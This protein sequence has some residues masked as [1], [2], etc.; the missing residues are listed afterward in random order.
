MKT[1]DFEPGGLSS[2]TALTPLGFEP[3]AA[4]QQP[5]QQEE[6]Y[7]GA[8]QEFGEGVAGGIIG[9]G[10]GI[11]ELGTALVDVAAGTDY[12]RSVSEGSRKLK[13]ALGIDPAG[14]IGK[15]AEI[16]TQFVIPGLGVAGAVS[17][18]SK[19]G[20]LQK[21][22]QSGKASALPGKGLT[23]G[24][25]FSL[26]LQ[27]VAA[28]AAVDAVVANDGTTT[29]GDFFGGGP[30]MT[31][32][33]IGAGGRENALRV[34]LNKGKIGI[35]AG[36]A[37]VAAAGA[38][39][40]MGKAAEKTGKYMAQA[41]LD[42]LRGA[43]D[44]FSDAVA[45]GASV[46][47]Y[48]G[49]LPDEVAQAKSLVQ[50][51]IESYISSAKKIARRLD[52]QVE[53]LVK[54][55]ARTG[56]TP[57]QKSQVYNLIDEFLTS[58]N[59]EARQRAFDLLP[60]NLQETAKLMRGS[61][62]QLSTEILDSNYLARLDE[63]VD[64]KNPSATLG[65]EVREVIQNNI[66]TYFRRRFRMFEMDGKFVPSDEVKAR[67]VEGFKGDRS[68]TAY[69]LGKI[70][71]D[72]IAS[73]KGLY[74]EASL[75]IQK[76]DNGK[77]EMIST[78]VTD[79][80]AKL[81]S[82]GF[83][84]RYKPSKER[85][86]LTGRIA[87]NKINY[88]MFNER[89]FMPKYQRD[90]LGE[91]TDV[92]EAYLGTV[93]DL[94]EFIATDRYFG[95]IDQLVKAKN[96]DGTFTN[97][98]VRALF[99]DTRDAEGLVGKNVPD[100]MKLL[101]GDDWGGLTGYAVDNKIYNDLTRLVI[102]D[103]GV[104]GNAARGLYSTFL[105]GKGFTQY[106]KTVLSIPTQIR[107]VTSAALF[108]TMQG[109]VG[110]GA[111]IME[112]F[113]LVWRPFAEKSSDEQ[114]KE[115]QKMQ[116][117]GVF[118]NQAQLKEMKEAISQGLGF[119][120]DATIGGV[121]V[122]RGYADGLY[123][124][125]F[126]PFLKHL[127][128]LTQGAKKVGEVAE[129]FYQGGD[130]LWKYYNYK[131]ERQK[132]VN[133]LDTMSREEGI[134]WLSKGKGLPTDMTFDDLIDTYAANIVRNVVPN[135]NLAP[136]FIRGLRKLPIGNFIAFPYEIYR[137]T[138]NTLKQG[139]DEMASNNAAVRAI[140][141]RR[142][143]GALATTT[144]V[145]ASLAQI[146][147][148]LTDVT[149]EETAAYQRSIS[150]DWEKN[151]T[152][153]PIGRNEDGVPIY[154][155]FSYTNPY[156]LL[157]K[158]VVGVLNEAEKGGLQGKDTGSIV[159]NAINAG[160][161]ELYKPFTEES[162]IAGLLRDVVDPDSEQ[163][164]IPGEAI[165]GQ[166]IGGRGGQRISGAKVY[167]DEDSWDVKLQKKVNHVV[168]GMAPGLFPW[169]VRGG[170]YELG[171]FGQSIA[172]AFVEEGE[173][174]RDRYGREREIGQELVRL[175]TGISQTE[176]DVPL[177]LRYRGYEFSSRLKNAANIFTNVASRQNATK[178]DFLNAYQRSQEARFRIKNDMYLMIQDM[179][180]LGMDE[181]DIKRVFKKAGIGGT[182][183]VFR[184]EYEPSDISKAVRQRARDNDIELP[185]DEL[186]D[187]MDI[188]ENKKFG[189]P[190]T[191][192]VPRPSTSSAPAM[193]DFEPSLP[194]A[195]V[196][197]PS[198]QGAAPAVGPTSS[199]TTGPAAPPPVVTPT[200]TPT[201]PSLLGKNPV[202]AMR[203][204]Q[205]AARSKT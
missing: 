69:E 24:E 26:G 136:E 190:S 153:V 51:E 46:L 112:S 14:F 167:N 53:G 54:E 87:L 47:R 27:Q 83:L 148:E 200:P 108:A 168:G 161:E 117:L 103:V 184:G 7:E 71:E 180:K 3:G 15:G 102:R 127:T 160:I 6:E 13:D 193:F 39:R 151:A 93:A 72:D 197:P 170:E 158:A 205:I 113:K 174:K 111:N 162:I 176:A 185:I 75:G 10:T 188:Y 106:G 35:E 28:A 4:P 56:G 63:I 74:S 25:R 178:D 144:I 100:G 110:R 65:Q 114:L 128:P 21:A 139:L 118:G 107:N 58:P 134:A 115:F 198:P 95:K 143:A 29:I 92:R 182:K 2:T 8:L 55:A 34:L 120:E 67:A 133:A 64:P 203:N 194:S 48:R 183:D 90:L 123:T 61:I 18:A 201:D 159:F 9:A 84:K 187:M 175:L 138:A 101:S 141:R 146:G 104:V 30:T 20:R 94:S 135:Y 173:N 73:G 142:M 31:E 181:D 66:D 172:N 98:G 126:H 52:K 202:T 199:N 204:A 16:V 150:P 171:R 130:D 45:K 32:K 86:T 157:S 147:H 49:F 124:G 163:A 59:A 37:T 154:I 1:F 145:P 152:L 22:I 85:D 62:T 91:I 125:S 155:N 105:Q 40:G 122:G 76:G 131:F 44:K 41:E 19:L 149:Q 116:R 82:D 11:L 88:K 196:S 36:G 70:L 119:T 97:P 191:K 80:Q 79:Q 23:K 177:A 42:Y 57:L 121:S 140:G 129:S 99:R 192:P 5:Q 81:A 78:E 156:D 132:I 60:T 179:K 43:G 77:W 166:L 165:L 195:P 12:T 96:A 68:R 89:K 38:V 164:V 17:K 137:T 189:V 109:N 50:G 169:V 186:K 33:D